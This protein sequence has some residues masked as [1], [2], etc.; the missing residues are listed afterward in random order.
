MS[1]H[2]YDVVIVGAG[3]GGSMAAKESAIDFHYPPGGTGVIF[4]KG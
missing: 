3:P 1:T 4:E 2:K